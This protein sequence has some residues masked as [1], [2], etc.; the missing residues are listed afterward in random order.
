M[1][2]VNNPVVMAAKQNE[3]I[4]RFQLLWCEPGFTPWSICAVCIYVANLSSDMYPRILG[5]R[6]NNRICAIRVGTLIP[7]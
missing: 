7:A 2:T 1:L 3:I 5:G 6:F 4:R